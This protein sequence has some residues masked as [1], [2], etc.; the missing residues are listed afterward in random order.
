MCLLNLWKLNV[1]IDV[2]YEKQTW[3]QLP[4]L[5]NKNMNSYFFIWHENSPK[6]LPPTAQIEH[7]QSWQHT[8][9]LWDLAASNE[10]YTVCVYIANLYH[11]F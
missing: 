8:H 1:Y 7:R 3:I 4:I 9:C 10:N 5:Y 2:R 6:V 11:S